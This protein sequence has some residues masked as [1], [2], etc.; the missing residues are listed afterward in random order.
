MVLAA[1][2]KMYCTRV[3]YFMARQDKTP[4]QEFNCGDKGLSWVVLM[5]TK[6]DITER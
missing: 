3:E 4:L 1:L 5:I 2:G 6:Q